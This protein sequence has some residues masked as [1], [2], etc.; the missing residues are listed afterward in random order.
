MLDDGKSENEIS[1]LIGCEPD[2][3]IRLAEE[4][5]KENNIIS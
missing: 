3:A 5:K 4:W 1:G 2:E